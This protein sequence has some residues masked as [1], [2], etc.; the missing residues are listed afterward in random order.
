MLNPYSPTGQK[1]PLPCPD[2]LEARREHDP[3]RWLQP[4]YNDGPA[5]VTD[6][7]VLQYPRRQSVCRAGRREVGERE[8]AG[9][10]VG[11]C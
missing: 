1:G 3:D 2:K 6:P 5:R 10:E 7:G 11:D 9:R 8:P 4:R